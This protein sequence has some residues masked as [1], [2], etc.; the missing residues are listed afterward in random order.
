[1]SPRT[2]QLTWVIGIVIWVMLCSAGWFVA[3]RDDYARL[4]AATACYSTSLK[5]PVSGPQ[6]ANVKPSDI[7]TYKAAIDRKAAI[8]RIAAALGTAA[9]LA[10]WLLL[11]RPGLATEPR[12]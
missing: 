6:C 3:T 8:S 1:M 7:R 11:G 4:N 9:A 5:S 10:L 12:R 2:L